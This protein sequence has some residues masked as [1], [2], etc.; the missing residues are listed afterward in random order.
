MK[1]FFKIDHVTIIKVLSVIIWLWI[2]PVVDAFDNLSYGLATSALLK[3][4]VFCAAG[5]VIASY[6]SNE[7]RRRMSVYILV[8]G[9][10]MLIVGYPCYNYLTGGHYCHRVIA[11][12]RFLG[13][14]CM[15]F[16]LEARDCFIKPKSTL[17]GVS[18]L[19]S[20]I[21]LYYLIMYLTRYIPSDSNAFLTVQSVVFGI[22]RVGISVFVWKLASIDCIM[23]LFKRVPKISLFV[24]GLFWGMIL[25]V[26][27]D[28]F[29]PRW[30]SILMLSLAPVFAYIITV[31]VRLSVQLISYVMKGII[32]NKFWW[33]ESC[34]WWINKTDEV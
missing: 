14:L 30:L 16:G 31:I 8:L 33:F 19:L 21:I 34:C 15:G 3:N 27:A 5:V 2:I 28:N 7:I 24:A 32:A 9:V 10:M 13:I 23:H 26:P 6:F 20:L 18:V 17:K 11:V 1:P 29:A 12:F 25:V 22:L 4:I